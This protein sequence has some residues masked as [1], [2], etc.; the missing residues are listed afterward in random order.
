[1]SFRGRGTLEVKPSKNPFFQTTSSDIGVKPDEKIDW[2]YDLNPS[3]LLSSQGTGSSDNFS[4]L[5]S[6]ESDTIG[7]KVKKPELMLPRMMT[8]TEFLKKRRDDLNSK[9]EVKE[10]LMEYKQTQTFA[11]HT[12]E[13]ILRNYRHEPKYEDP[14]YTLTSNEHGKKIP[15]VAT[16]VAERS[17]RPQGFSKSFANIKPESSSLNTGITKST[18]HPTLDPQFV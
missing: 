5:Y 2:T 13:E 14:R 16:F 4:F 1:M 8:R 18:V 11:K 17:C 7:S 12:A 10:I 3:L 9:E 15:T 6:R